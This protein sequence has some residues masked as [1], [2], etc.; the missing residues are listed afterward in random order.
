MHAY[1]GSEPIADA[2]RAGADIVIT[3][4]AADAALFAGPVRDGLDGSPDALAGALAV[5]H[6]LECSGQVTGGNFEAPGERPPTAAEFANLGFPLADVAPTGAL[7]SQSS[8]APEVGSTAS[9]AR[10]SCSTRCTTPAAT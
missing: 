3:G 10:C 7:R 8:T 1:I 2:L 6:L 5:G 4:R 9:P